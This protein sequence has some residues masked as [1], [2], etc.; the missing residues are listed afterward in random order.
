MHAASHFPLPQRWQGSI[1]QSRFAG[2]SRPR[3]RKNRAIRH[4]VESR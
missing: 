2:K 1:D 3:E 4:L